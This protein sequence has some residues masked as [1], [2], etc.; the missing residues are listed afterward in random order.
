MP[1]GS[2]ISAFYHDGAAAIVV[3]G[4]LRAAAAQF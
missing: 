3:V 4:E 1:A 2:G